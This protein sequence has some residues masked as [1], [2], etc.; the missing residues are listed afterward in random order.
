VGDRIVQ[1][2]ISVVLNLSPEH[3]DWH[4]SEQTYRNDKLRLA[5]LAGECP[6]VLNAGDS[7]LSDLFAG[8]EN[9]TWFNSAQGIRAEKRSLFAGNRL[10]PLTAPEGLPGA[11][12]LSNTAA[13]LTVAHM[14]GGDLTTGVRSVASFRS[15]P[16]RLQTVGE[17]GGVRYV[18]DSISS[19]PLAT[20]AALEALDS[21]SVTLLVGGLDRGID[22]S[23][24]LDRIRARLPLAIIGVPDNGARVTRDMSRAGI[25]PPKGLHLTDSLEK[26]VAMAAELTPAGGVVLL[27][28][29]AP[30]FPQ[31]MDFRDRGRQFTSWCGFRLEETE[32]F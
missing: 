2:S 5:T 16:H 20:A 13:A 23:P 17:K 15:L 22:W 28:P 11:H 26:A 25:H 21:R 29:G 27:S 18:N 30:S 3:L 8:R 19:T 14:I 12:N 32:T 10:L 1:P 31:F 4:G 24:Y 9:V 7:L 6:L